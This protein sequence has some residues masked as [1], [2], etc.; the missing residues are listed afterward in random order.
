[1]IFPHVR[2][3]RFFGQFGFKMSQTELCALKQWSVWELTTTK[4]TI[5]LKFY[6]R[7]QVFHNF[8]TELDNWG[9]TYEGYPVAGITN[10]EVHIR[11]RTES[12]VV[13]SISKWYCLLKSN[14]NLLWE[15]LARPIARLIL[16]GGCGGL[17]VG[18]CLSGLLACGPSQYLGV[19]LNF[20]CSGALRKWFNFC[21]SRGFSSI[22][23]IF[24]LAGKLGAIILFLS[25]SPTR[26]T[27]L[28]YHFCN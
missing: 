8:T 6:V 22:N 17:C 7:Y 23:K 20:V 5:Q 18:V 15:G 4:W 9:P 26:K 27:T 3:K 12:L 28:I 16:C 24:V 10:S 13:K 21:F 1:M 19:A 2:R 11:R 25:C 14:K